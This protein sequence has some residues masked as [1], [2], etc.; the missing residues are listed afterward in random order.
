MWLFTENFP[1]ISS[2]NYNTEIYGTEKLGILQPTA[3]KGMRTKNMQAK[4]LG[5]SYV[6]VNWKC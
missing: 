6:S 2:F 4:V 3:R 5:I 1:E